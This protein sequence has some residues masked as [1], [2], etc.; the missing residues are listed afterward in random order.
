MFLNRLGGITIGIS[1]KKYIYI[2]LHRLNDN[3]I[4]FPN[5]FMQLS[6]TVLQCG[7]NYF[8]FMYG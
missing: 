2:L 7:N 8:I 6:S 3:T 1:S 5:Y 4:V